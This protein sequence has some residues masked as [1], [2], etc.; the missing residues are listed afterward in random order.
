[1]II[2]LLALVVAAFCLGLFIGYN[3]PHQQ[4]LLPP[5]ERK[6][7]PATSSIP[8]GDLSEIARKLAEEKP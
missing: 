3:V 1:V 6:P 7:E 2:L 4:K 5:P 8:E